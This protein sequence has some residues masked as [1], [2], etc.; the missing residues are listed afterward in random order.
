MDPIPT[1]GLLFGNHE[2]CVVATMGTQ[3]FR[4][5]PSELIG[6]IVLAP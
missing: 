3:L 5:R 6:R 1:R 4:V 2:W